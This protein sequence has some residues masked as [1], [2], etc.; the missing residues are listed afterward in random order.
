M[1]QV[2]FQPCTYKEYPKLRPILDSY[3]EVF[4]F[5]QKRQITTLAGKALD[6]GFAGPTVFMAM[7]EGETIGFMGGLRNSNNPFQLDM[8]CLVI[9]RGY[10]NQ[11]VGTKLFYYA[12]EELKQAGFK[13]LLAHLKGTYPP[14]TKRYYTKLG[15]KQWFSED[16]TGAS[17]EDIAMMKMLD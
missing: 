11:G 15:F 16:F 2:V 7:H 1:N 9:K 13:Q 12:V 5:F 14:R 17:D 3:S 8:F 10:N 6:E 4:D